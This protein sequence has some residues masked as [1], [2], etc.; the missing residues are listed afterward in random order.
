MDDG[1]RC[2][3]VERDYYDED[4]ITL[5]YATTDGRRQLTQQKSTVLLV[6]QPVT[7]AKTVDP[8]RL[9]PVPGSDRDQYASEARRM[10]ER[11]DPDDE[12]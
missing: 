6:K 2:W 5:V 3:L 12:V 9:E 7:A 11:H 10:A 1:V 8:D 4:L